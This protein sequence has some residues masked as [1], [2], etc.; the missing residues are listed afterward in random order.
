MPR[1]FDNIEETLLPA[2][3]ETSALCARADFCVGYF[4]LRG[5]RQLHDYID[6]WP[7]G[8]GNCCRLLVGMQT[9]PAD[10]LRAPLSLSTAP[11][12]MDN[13]TALRVKRALAE[14]V[15]VLYEEDRLCIGHE[16]QESREPRIICSLGLVQAN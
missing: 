9:L 15:M 7:G 4:N 14:L 16:E 2:L 5:W 13:A 8:E 12:R 11:A 3:Q 1:I 10:E 6:K